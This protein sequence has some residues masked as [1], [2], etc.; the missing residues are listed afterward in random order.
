MSHLSSLL[1]GP[2]KIYILNLNFE[3]INI[4][5]IKYKINVYCIYIRIYI[6]N[7]HI[8]LCSYLSIDMWL[9]ETEVDTLI[10][11][12]ALSNLPFLSLKNNQTGLERWL[13]EKTWV[14][15]P[16][17]HGSSQLSETLILEQLKPSSGLSMHCIQAHMHTCI[18]AH[19]Q[20]K[21]PST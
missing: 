12:H 4:Y 13:L 1:L 17:P 14:Q 8:F 21:H 9:R 3:K 15:F 2:F 7:L 19:M 16:A 10:S 6:Y 5:F 18:H 20:A 11:C